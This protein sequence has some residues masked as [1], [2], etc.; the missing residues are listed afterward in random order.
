MVSCCSKKKIPEGGSLEP[1]PA[2]GTSPAATGGGSPGSAM[3]LFNPL[4]PKDNPNCEVT[5]NSLIGRFVAAFLGMVGALAL[6]V[7]VYAGVIYMTAGSS[8][9]IKEARDT[10]KY[11][12]LGLGLIVF[13]YVLTNF[14]F[15]ALTSSPPT[16][17]PA[18]KP[19]TLPTQ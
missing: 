4:C 2:G 15:N 6:L 14:F 3:T 9:R 12:V 13:A 8:D 17:K 5:L 1:T 11:A 19:V 10:M 7:F 18:S 16:E